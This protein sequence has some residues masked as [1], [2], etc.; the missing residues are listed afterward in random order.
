MSISLTLLSISLF[1]SW[2]HTKHFVKKLIF[3]SFQFNY[4]HNIWWLLQLLLS[5]MVW[6]GEKF[7][8]RKTNLLKICILVFVRVS[9]LLRL[10]LSP[11]LVIVRS[12][13]S[14]REWKW[15]AWIIKER[16][17]SSYLNSRKWRREKKLLFELTR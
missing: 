12:R 13:S 5:A 6:W 4:L 11:P 14:S 15:T 3:F 17:I 10:L 8:F 1:F 2:V 9:F 7:L 16:K